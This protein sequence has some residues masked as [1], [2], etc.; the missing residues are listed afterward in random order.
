MSLRAFKGCG[1]NV[2]VNRFIELEAEAKAIA[3]A[4]AAEAADSKAAAADGADAAEE[5]PSKA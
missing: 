3:D 2:I 5:P 1:A 4:K